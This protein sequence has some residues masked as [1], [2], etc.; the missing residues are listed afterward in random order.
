MK[1]RW[2]IVLGFT[3]ITILGLGVKFYMDEEKLNKEMINVVFSD[4][5]KRVFENGLKNLD[6]KALTGEGVINTYE[7]DKKSIKQ[8]PMGGIN[9]T[10][11]VN[12]NPELYVFFTL[13]NTDDKKMIDD[14]GGNSAKL[15]MLLEGK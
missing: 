9:V 15:E 5:A 4:E 6:A 12:E 13:N 11:Y 10:L 1:K 7:I 8:N 14:G 2:I 3:V